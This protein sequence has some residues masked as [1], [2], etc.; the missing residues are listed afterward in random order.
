M[1]LWDI[2]LLAFNFAKKNIILLAICFQDVKYYIPVLCVLM[3]SCQLFVFHKFVEFSESLH[4][5]QLR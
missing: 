1:T 4:S 2:N 3:K 5:V